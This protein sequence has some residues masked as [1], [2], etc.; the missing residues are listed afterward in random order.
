MLC[1]IVS[2]NLHLVV[3]ECV[4]V[5]LSLKIKRVIPAGSMER[6]TCPGKNL[7]IVQIVIATENKNDIVSL[8]P[9]VRI[10]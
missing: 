10:F 5:R 3:V 7:L 2:T 4:P 9:S 6:L 8:A 1:F